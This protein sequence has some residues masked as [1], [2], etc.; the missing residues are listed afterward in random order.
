MS[1]AAGLIRIGLIIKA[2]GVRGELL[3][4][5][6]TDDIRR[7]ERLIQVF[8]EKTGGSGVNP[9]EIE[10][11]RFHKDK[12]LLKFKHFDDINA[13][14][15]LKGSYIS[16]EEKDLVKL[17]DDS[18]FVFDLQGCEV[19]NVSGELL[20]ILTDVLETGSNDVYKVTPATANSVAVG[21]VTVGGVTADGA[22]ADGSIAGGP[23]K[24]LLIPAIKSV[25]KEVSVKD[26]KIIADF[27][28]ESE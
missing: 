18:Y 8:V 7:F 15:S 25:I 2:H 14:I 19:Y 6:L 21:G 5:P 17:P 26:K 3:V 22:T 27:A 10:Y 24:E 16:I 11:V 23:P 28:P 12:L 13:V 1:P 4:K 20:G 9:Y